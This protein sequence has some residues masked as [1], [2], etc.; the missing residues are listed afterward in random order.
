MPKMSEVK[1]S[2]IKHMLIYGPPKAG[3]TRLVGSLA[4]KYNLH[5]LDLEYGS[6]TLKQLPSE[7]QERIEAY[8]IPDNKALP[9]AVET[10]L[11]LFTVK[12][13]DICAAHGKF[14]CPLCTKENKERWPIDITKFTTNDILV[15]DSWTQVVLSALANITRNKGDDYKMEWD[16]WNHLKQVMENLLTLVQSAPFHVVV[17]SHEDVVEMVDKTE[18]IVP[19]G[20]SSKT[21]RNMAKYFG[22]VI[23]LEVSNKKHKAY[24]STVARNNILT[25]SRSQVEFEKTDTPDLIEVFDRIAAQ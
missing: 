19:V 23:Y 12:T 3:K 13:G 10:L 4:R 22:E 24:S 7:W 14:K 6:D 20:G 17:I 15:I 1:E 18:K 25:G 11:K 9:I 2:V 16:E 8:F 5:W 21:S